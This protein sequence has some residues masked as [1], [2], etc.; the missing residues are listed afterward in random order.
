MN[1]SR[2]AIGSVYHASR[3]SPG[4]LL[5]PLLLVLH[6]G[7]AV[8]LRLRSLYKATSTRWRWGEMATGSRRVWEAGGVA[9]VLAAGCGASPPYNELRAGRACVWTAGLPGSELLQDK[10]LWN[11]TRGSKVSASAGTQT[12][13]HAHHS[14]AGERDPSQQREVRGTSGTVRDH[15][16]GVGATHAPSDHAQ[17]H[18][19]D[20][21]RVFTTF[22]SGSR[23]SRL[24]HLSFSPVRESPIQN[25]V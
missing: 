16:G 8:F 20:Q 22:W 4:A 12:S 1:A 18:A 14:R 5:L 3:F 21:A 13:E 24:D 2:A 11:A 7:A 17:G 6:G 10:P 23:P 25:H 19:P 9:A 15:A